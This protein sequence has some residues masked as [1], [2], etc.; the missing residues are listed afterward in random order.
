M[1][2]K[3]LKFAAVPL[4]VL[5]LSGTVAMAQTT[6]APDAGPGQTPTS[7]HSKPRKG[8]KKPGHKK[9]GKKK[10]AKKPAQ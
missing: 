5:V 10:K 4:G 7:S 2:P 6:P 3:V 8:N 9:A 1:M